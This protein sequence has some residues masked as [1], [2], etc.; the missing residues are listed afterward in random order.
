MTNF[1]LSA[2]GVGTETKPRPNPIGNERG[3]TMVMLVIS[4][5]IFCLIMDAVI[6]SIAVQMQAQKET[7]MQIESRTVASNVIS[8]FSAPSVCQSNIDQTMPLS[9]A[10]AMASTGVALR[11]TLPGGAVVGE[12]ESVPNLPL[13]VRTFRFSDATFIGL[14]AGGF[15]EYLGKLTV[16][17]ERTDTLKVYR[18]REVGMVTVL[19]TATGA[20]TEFARG[21]AARPSEDAAQ[22][23]CTSMGGTYDTATSQCNCAAQATAAANGMPITLPTALNG[24]LQNDT[25]GTSKVSHLCVSGKWAKII[26]ETAGGPIVAGP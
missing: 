20:P 2:E 1:T 16:G 4:I 15:A 25:V 11:L 26:D 5:A 7:E 9:L 19:M 24:T 14:K 12:G 13:R 10:A 18:P 8:V 23:V 3:E 6:S 21:C 17:M 22:S